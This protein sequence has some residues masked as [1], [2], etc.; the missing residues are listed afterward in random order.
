MKNCTA[1]S[2]KLRCGKVALACRFPAGFKPPRLVTHVKDL[3]SFRVCCIFGC[4][5]FPSEQPFLSSS[6]GAPFF[7]FGVPSD[8]APNARPA[9][10]NTEERHKD[11]QLIRHI[12]C[13]M[14]H[15]MQNFLEDCGCGCVWAVPEF[16]CMKQGRKGSGEP[17]KSST[18]AP[19]PSVPPPEALYDKQ[20]QEAFSNRK[21]HFL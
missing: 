5:L 3:L 4:F 11:F 12:K 19:P 14:W 21:G 20:S 2:K 1:T 10:W 9:Q 16:C 17:Q 13:L 15:Q 7:I 6:R 8:A 18:I